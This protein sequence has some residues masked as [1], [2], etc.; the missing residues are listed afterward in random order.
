MLLSN[1]KRGVGNLFVLPK[2]AV[3]NMVKTFFAKTKRNGVCPDHGYLRNL[4]SDFTET[5]SIV[6]LDASLHLYKRVCPLVG[7]AVGLSVGNAFL[8]ASSHLYKRVCPL[9]RRSV[10]PSVRNAFVKSGEMEHLQF[11]KYATSCLCQFFSKL[12]RLGDFFNNR[13]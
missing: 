8:D 12:N 9:D 2:S 5:W 4:H 13:M 1:T 7:L 3:Q 10:G 6:F 11:R